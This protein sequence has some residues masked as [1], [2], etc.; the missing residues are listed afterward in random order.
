MVYGF[1]D[2]TAI[3]ISHRPVGLEEFDRILLLQ[4]GRLT[5]VDPKGL[6]RMLASS[7]KISARRPGPGADLH[8]REPSR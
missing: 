5:L 8:A 2:R 7:E 4:G 1:P 6:A 3:V